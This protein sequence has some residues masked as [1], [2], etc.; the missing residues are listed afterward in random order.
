M[1]FNNPFSWLSY[2][3]AFFPQDLSSEKSEN[4]RCL[5]ITSQCLHLLL[6]LLSFIG[7]IFMHV[8]VICKTICNISDPPEQDVDWKEGRF[9]LHC[10]SGKMISW[11]TRQVLYALVLAFVNRQRFHGLLSAFR[12]MF[13]LGSWIRW[14]TAFYSLGPAIAHLLAEFY[15]VSRVHA[16]F[17]W[18]W[19]LR[20]KG[21]FLANAAFVE[22]EF[23]E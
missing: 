6:F 21:G 2:L 4:C 18:G 14:Q 9:V 3:L 1:L 12:K 16:V 20:R 17:A 10:G 8:S 7:E 19:M 23:T 13:G 11:R 5:T 15:T 22:S